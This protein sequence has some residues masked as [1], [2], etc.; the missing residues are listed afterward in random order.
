M[1]GNGRDVINV[2][3]STWL[4]RRA[5]TRKPSVGLVNVPSV[6]RVIMQMKVGRELQENLQSSVYENEV[7]ENGRTTLQGNMGQKCVISKQAEM[8][9][10]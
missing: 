4:E 7:S 5:I 1:A 6:I 10:K 8:D 2:H 9:L 3:P